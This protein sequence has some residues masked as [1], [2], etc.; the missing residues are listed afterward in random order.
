MEYGKYLVMIS[1]LESASNGRRPNQVVPPHSSGSTPMFR[2]TSD[3][4]R[5]AQKKQGGDSQNS[6]SEICPRP[7]AEYRS[8]AKY[9][10]HPHSERS[11]DKLNLKLSYTKADT[12][13]RYLNTDYR[14]K[15]P[16]YFEKR[17]ESHRSQKQGWQPRKKHL[18]GTLNRRD[19]RRNWTSQRTFKMC[20]ELKNWAIEICF[21]GNQNQNSNTQQGN[22]LAVMTVM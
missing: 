9:W 2:P 1:H 22:K 8:A 15:Y 4:K 16:P 3:Q 5:Y 20:Q 7:M 6:T 17:K 18:K 12:P 11:N 13:P 14:K 19:I 10:Q 21:A